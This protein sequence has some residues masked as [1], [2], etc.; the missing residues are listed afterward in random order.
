MKQASF[1]KTKTR[2]AAAISL[3]SLA[4]FVGEFLLGNLPVTMVWLLPYLALLYGCGALLIRETAV[5]QHLNTGGL[6]ILCLAYGIVEEA[7]HT[8]SLFDPNY[9][10]LRLL[11][12]GYLSFLKMGSW[13]TVFALGIHVIWSTAVPIALLDGLFPESKGKPVLGTSGIIVVGLAFVFA[14]FT[15]L[16]TKSKEAFMASGLQFALA[17]LVVVLLVILAV[18]AFRKKKPERMGSKRVPGP[19]A[20][21]L[22]AFLL[23]SGFMA[24]TFLITYIPAWGSIGAMILIFVAGCILLSRW[25]NHSGWSSRHSLM[26]TGGLLFTYA[27][28]GFVQV[29]SLGSITPLQDTL[30]NILFACI[31]LGL[32]L[33]AWRKT[34]NLKKERNP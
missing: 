6:L 10:G 24:T 27:W 32:F 29:P 7:F 23:G 16:L 1:P 3:F 2:I 30:G 19:F 17:G 9:V 25:S 12:Y 20:V 33:I 11:D 22:T 34:R 4:P 21:G 31:A 8:Q 15:P 28:Y 26:G 14:A 13:W 18:S 5:R